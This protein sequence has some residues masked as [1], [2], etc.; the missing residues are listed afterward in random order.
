MPLAFTEDFN[1]DGFHDRTPTRIRT[2]KG[3]L[4]DP[5]IINTN[6]EP[7]TFQVTHNNPVGSIS[8]ISQTMNDT[9]SL[10]GKMITSASFTV[11]IQRPELMEFFN[12]TGGNYNFIYKLTDGTEV[13]MNNVRFEPVPD[14]RTGIMHVNG[15]MRTVGYNPNKHT[16]PVKKTKPKKEKTLIPLSEQLKR[17][18][19]K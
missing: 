15:P 12:N 10:N 4:T 19:V 3:C 7:V 14:E 8:G 9:S 6:N 5:I 13:T 1:L 17:V 16:K 11:D 2:F 18:K